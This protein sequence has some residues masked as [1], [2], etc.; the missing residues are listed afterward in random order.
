MARVS[1]N[2]VMSDS[3]P[4]ATKARIMANNQSLLINASKLYGDRAKLA[5]MSKE[6]L[7]R[8]LVQLLQK[9]GFVV[10]IPG[11]NLHVRQDEQPVQG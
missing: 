3:T 5:G 4:A 1:F 6:Q 10:P 7:E 9:H 11:I 8:R 2:L